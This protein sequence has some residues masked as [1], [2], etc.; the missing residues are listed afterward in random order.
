M[1][2]V[3]PKIS[4]GSYACNEPQLL[5]VL[6]YA[7]RRRIIGDSMPMLALVVSVPDEYCTSQ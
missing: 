2:Y 1:M 4:Q 7:V 3:C 6:H 5:S